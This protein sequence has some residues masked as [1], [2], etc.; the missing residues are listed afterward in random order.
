MVRSGVRVWEPVEVF[1]WF[2]GTEE[3]EYIRIEVLYMLRVF[4]M[5]VNKNRGVGKI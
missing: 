2:R 1:K 3:W 4:D 5:L